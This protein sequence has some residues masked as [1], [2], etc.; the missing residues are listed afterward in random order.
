[1]L[2]QPSSNQ[3]KSDD[4]PGLPRATKIVPRAYITGSNRTL[5]PLPEDCERRET[6]SSNQQT[7]SELYVYVYIYIYIYI[8]LCVCVCVYVCMY[9]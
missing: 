8:Y 7:L 9:F 4:S 6:P 5:S 3:K 2:N 1:M